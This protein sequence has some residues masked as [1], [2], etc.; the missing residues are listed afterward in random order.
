MTEYTV[1]GV[2]ADVDYS[3]LGI[4]AQLL[5]RINESFYTTFAVGGRIE[6]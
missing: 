4:F 3:N 2:D 1:M 6:N 5:K